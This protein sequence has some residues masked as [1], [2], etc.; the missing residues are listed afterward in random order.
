MQRRRAERQSGK[1]GKKL[2]GL[3]RGFSVGNCFGK[4]GVACL[5]GVRSNGAG[6]RFY[7]CHEM[8]GF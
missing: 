8:V 6:L 1:W 2:S 7:R 4:V 5:L 3:I